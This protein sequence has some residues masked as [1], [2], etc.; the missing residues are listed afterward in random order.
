MVELDAFAS[1]GPAIAEPGVA[2]LQSAVEVL[3]SA[4]TVAEA[5]IGPDYISLRAIEGEQKARE[6]AAAFHAV[7]HGLRLLYLAVPAP[8]RRI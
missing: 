3:V 1:S 5:N 8:R 6:I 7:M 2:V 4:G